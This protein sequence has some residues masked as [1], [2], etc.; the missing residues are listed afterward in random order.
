MPPLPQG[1]FQSSWQ[2][3]T[4]IVTRGPGRCCSFFVPR[5]KHGHRSLP[6]A[7]SS[8]RKCRST[9]AST[10]CRVSSPSGFPAQFLPLC[11][12]THLAPSRQQHSSAGS[13]LKLLISGS[14][15]SPREE[16]HP[17]VWRFVLGHKV[18]IHYKDLGVSVQGRSRQTDS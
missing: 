8:L 6:P 11:H 12:V 10:A 15:P 16:F 18:R 4:V 17:R 2:T 7:L 5:R 9:P 3:P 14:L 1:L 13:S